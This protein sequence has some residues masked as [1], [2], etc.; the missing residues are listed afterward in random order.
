M[1]IRKL[2]PIA[3]SL[4]IGGCAVNYDPNTSSKTILVDFPPIGEINT[5]YVGDNMMSKDSNLSQRLLC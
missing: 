1:N 4:A 3:L 2:L 5:A